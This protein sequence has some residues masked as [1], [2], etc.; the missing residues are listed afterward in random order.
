MSDTSLQ[1]IHE[2]VARIEAAADGRC[3]TCRQRDSRVRTHRMDDGS[4]LVWHCNVK[5][6]SNHADYQSSQSSR[7]D[8]QA[9]ADDGVDRFHEHLDNCSRCGEQP[10][11]LC[12]AGLKLLQ[13]VALE[14]IRDYKPNT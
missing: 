5:G 10:F 3:G 9:P 11:N 13:Q 2:E 14:A 12:P 1:K 4:V 8:D 6:C 7:V